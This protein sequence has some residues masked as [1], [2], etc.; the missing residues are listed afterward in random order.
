MSVGR[1][2]HDSGLSVEEEVRLL[3]EK[4]RSLTRIKAELERDL[5]Y[6]QKEVSKLL[7]PPHIEATVL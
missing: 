6:Y 2:P 1:G 3:K 7:S 5:E 4:V